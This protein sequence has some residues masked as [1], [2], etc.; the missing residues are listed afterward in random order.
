MNLIHGK[1]MNAEQSKR[2]LAQI[3]E[4]VLRSLAAGRLA[5]KDVIAACDK[6]SRKL[7]EQEHLALLV[8]SGMRPELAKT[9]LTAFKSMLSRGYLERRVEREFGDWTER[10]FQPL[11]MDRSVRQKWAPLGVLLHISAGN[12]DALP[13]YSVIEGLLT[14]N[15]NILKLP[16]DGDELSLRILEELIGIE[17]RIAEKVF[18]FDTPSDDIAAMERLADAADAIVVWGGDAAVSAVRSMA[19]PDTRIVEWGHKISF[20]YVSGDEVSDG[21]LTELARHIC[22]TNQLL[23]NSCQGIYVDTDSFEQVTAFAERFYPILERAAEEDPLPDNPFRA[24]QATLALY[25]EELEAVHMK[26]RVFRGKRCGVVA[27][28]DSALTPSCTARCVWVRALPGECILQTLKPYKNHLQ[29]AALVCGKGEIRKFEEALV[30]AGAVRIVSVG[31]ISAHYC[32]MPH[33]GEFALRR[34]MRIV[35]CEYEGADGTGDRSNE[36]K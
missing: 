14:E 19:K 4:S 8:S 20:A 34:Y 1:R 10:T 33:D 28:G 7:S 36:T 27:Y 24:A 11:D 23:C 17:P 2:E 35:S 13:A 31:G 25:T 30:A 15:V 26:K 21:E 6:L 3:G 22:E 16:G 9:E 18:V 12:A 29:T 5:R 32:G